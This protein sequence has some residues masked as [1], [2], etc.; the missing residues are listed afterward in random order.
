MLWCSCVTRLGHPLGETGWT[1]HAGVP[2][3]APGTHAGSAA[4]K[5][6]VGL[7]KRFSWGFN[8]WQEALCW[9]GTDSVLPGMLENNKKPSIFY[10]CAKQN[11]NV[12]FLK[13]PNP[14][15]SPQN[16]NK[17]A[18]PHPPK[19]QSLHIQEENRGEKVRLSVSAITAAVLLVKEWKA[20][21]K[22]KDGRTVQISHACVWDHDWVYSERWCEKKPFVRL[23][24]QHNFLAATIPACLGW[25]LCWLEQVSV[26]VSWI[27]MLSKALI[28]LFSLLLTL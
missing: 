10:F 26:R 19:S 23:L 16:P 2:G 9:Y 25:V 24:F 5:S 7:L 4:S 17:L 6:H 13:K 20:E 3:A 15:Q 1:G 21:Q 8:Y 11:Q 28:F 12:L 27:F 22:R 18:H 14:T